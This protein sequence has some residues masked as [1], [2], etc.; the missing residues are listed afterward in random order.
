MS[1]QTIQD[2][3]NKKSECVK[4]IQNE[5]G[6]SDE[7]K[8]FDC[9]NYNGNNVDFVCCRSCKHV[10][11]YNSK[12]GTGTLSRHKCMSQQDAL[13]SQ[14]KL[15]M[16][17]KKVVSTRFR[18]S[19]AR[20]QLA[21]VAKDLHPFNIIESSG[22]REYSQALLNIGAEF[23]SQSFDDLVI[24]R[25]VLS[26]TIM[27]K[28]YETLKTQ[29][30]ISLKD[31]QLAYTTDMWSDDYT[32]RN[33]ITLTAHYMDDSFKLNVTLLGIREF[34]DEKKTGENILKN[35][36]DILQDFNTLETI[37]RAVF[38]TDNGANV[39]AA[40]KS[41]KRLSCVCHN[42]N[43]VMDDVTEKNPLVEAKALIDCCKSLVKYFK[44]SQLNSKL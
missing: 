22:F 18:D 14:P 13:K 38:V 1:R 11:V 10:L 24:S 23:G 36:Q 6:R 42:L 35:V 15:D 8:L 28:E 33:F 39:V 43:L 12:Q 27:E 25:K 7:W 4:L 26:T 2:A 40:F 21:L 44:H 37:D 9:V 17:A 16:F 30:I 31:Q 5:K 19:F 3:V 41:F 29:R 34:L 32:Q 20:K